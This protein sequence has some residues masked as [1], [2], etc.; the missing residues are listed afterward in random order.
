MIPVL[1]NCQGS[2]DNIAAV[3]ILTESSAFLLKGIC[4]YAENGTE[5]ITA[6]ARKRQI[7]VAFGTGEPLMMK[8][9]Y[10]YSY[11]NGKRRAVDLI[12]DFVQA[13]DNAVIVSEAPLTNI[14]AFLL[15]YPYMAEKI[16]YIAI[17]GGSIYSGNSTPCAEKNIYDDPE[18][19]QIVIS[20]SAPVVL[21]PLE[22]TR[23]S[24]NTLM[25]VLYCLIDTTCADTVECGVEIELESSCSRGCSIVDR[26][27]MI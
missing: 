21:F 9:N 24:S 25:T 23:D 14:A 1:L 18:A 22:A 5:E 3:R 10:T 19:A 2:S 27:I 6:F 26:K 15:C 11:G 7:P 12:K 13:N 8:E 20:S 16:K 4:V 17:A